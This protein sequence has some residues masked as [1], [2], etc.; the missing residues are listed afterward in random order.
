M[1]ESQLHYS[2]DYL[3]L[4]SLSKP[5]EG[6]PT[7]RLNLGNQC[8]IP[9]RTAIA[10]KCVSLHRFPPPHPRPALFC[11]NDTQCEYT[12]VTYPSHFLSGLPPLSHLRIC[13]LVFK[14]QMLALLGAISTILKSPCAT[15]NLNPIYLDHFLVQLLFLQLTVFPFVPSG[16]QI[17]WLFRYREGKYIMQVFQT[18][19]QLGIKAS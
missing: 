19:M 7:A 17:R 18:S 10:S 12:Y 8:A 9:I 14:I 16:M 5:D 6:P 2:P 11:S 13:E 3:L 15:P 4:L 1:R